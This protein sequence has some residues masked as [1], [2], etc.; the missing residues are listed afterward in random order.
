M[1][2]TEINI[3]GDKL[4]EMI[5]NSTSLKKKLDPVINILVDDFSSV[6]IRAMEILQFSLKIKL[7]NS[8]S[9]YDKNPLIIYIETL[10]SAYSLRY[11]FEA[12]YTWF[13]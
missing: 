12:R 3:S 13:V 6:T 7:K 8:V 1:I 10:H 11:L 2:N 4:K 5:E 9:R